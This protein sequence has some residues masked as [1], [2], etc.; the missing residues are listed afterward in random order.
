[1]QIHKYNYTLVRSDVYIFMSIY[2]NGYVCKESTEYFLQN[3]SW[4]NS[5]CVGKVD[6]ITEGQIAAVKNQKTKCREKKVRSTL[7][8]GDGGK[9]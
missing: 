8:G 4:T 1:M 5:L 2:I 6:T 7:R 3:L 9:F